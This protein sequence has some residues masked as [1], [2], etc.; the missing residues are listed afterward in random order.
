MNSKKV[1]SSTVN[2][3]LKDTVSST[4]AKNEIKE[5]KIVQLEIQDQLK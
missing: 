4:T 1:D 5:L 2:Q 3:D